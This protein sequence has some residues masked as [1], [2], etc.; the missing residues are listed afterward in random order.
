MGS[1]VF[2][3]AHGTSPTQRMTMNTVARR[4]HALVE[5]DL[6]ALAEIVARRQTKTF[7]AFPPMGT[8]SS[9]AT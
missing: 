3:F 5:G 2:A 8:E 1:A 4:S 9:R 6:V 7:S